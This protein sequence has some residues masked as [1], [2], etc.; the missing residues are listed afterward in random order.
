MPSS[1]GSCPSRIAFLRAEAVRGGGGGGDGSHGEADEA[2][3][4]PASVAHQMPTAVFRPPT[5]SSS[6]F[7]K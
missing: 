2:S 5:Y 3:G 1:S 4:H 7:R 6:R